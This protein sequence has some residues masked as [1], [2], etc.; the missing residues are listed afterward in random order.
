MDL[1]LIGVQTRFKQKYFINL[2]AYKAVFFIFS[3]K[4]TQGAKHDL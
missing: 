4:S 2:S 3:K 1:K